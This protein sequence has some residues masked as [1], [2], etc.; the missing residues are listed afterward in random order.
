[1]K[2]V[3]L[4]PHVAGNSKDALDNTSLVVSQ[5]VKKV[6]SGQIPKNLIN[7]QQLVEKGYIG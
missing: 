5:E 3:I 1:M 7:K 2:N 6:L 4:T